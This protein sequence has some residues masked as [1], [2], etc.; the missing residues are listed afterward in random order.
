[1]QLTMKSIPWMKCIV[2]RTPMIMYV[3]KYAEEKPS[4]SANGFSLISH[5][6]LNLHVLKPIGGVRPG[7]G[8]RQD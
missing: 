8:G 3:S 7:I 4:I 1:M 6:H 2:S 5:E